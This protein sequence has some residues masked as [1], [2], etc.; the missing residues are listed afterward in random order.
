[1]IFATAFEIFNHV[2]LFVSLAFICH[3][4]WNT[5]NRFDKFM[6][7]NGMLGGKQVLISGLTLTF[8]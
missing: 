7:V 2:I 8:G 5:L 3:H 4:K 6:F 1:M